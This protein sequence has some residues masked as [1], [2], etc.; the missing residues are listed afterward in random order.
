M[1]SNR[2]KK[3]IVRRK[4]GKK[5]STRKF[6]GWILL[7]GGMLLGLCIAVFG[8]I[9]GWVPKPDNPNNKPVAQIE[10][11]PSKIKTNDISENVLLEPPVTQTDNFDFYTTL[12]DMEVIIDT[13]SIDQASERQ[14]NTYFIQLGSFKN[15][16]D[17][18][19]LKAQVAFTGQATS[20]ETVEIK[21]AIWYRVRI[22]PYTSSRTADVDKRNL[23][24]NNFNP[25]IIK[26]K[27]D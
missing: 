13:S 5:A 23:E 3:K 21:Q 2:T 24:S 27:P 16:A 25:I 11:T 20:I 22:G 15:L 12:Q 17:A 1:V 6:P 8:Y 19:S 10:P 7:L 26:I 9:N 14:S 4:A 18:E